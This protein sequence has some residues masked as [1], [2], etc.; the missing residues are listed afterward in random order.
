MGVEI[1]VRHIGYAGPS[2]SGGVTSWHGRSGAV[3]IKDIDA[4]VGVYSGGTG[5]GTVRKLNFIGAGNTFFHNSTTNTVDISITGAGGTFKHY[6]AGIATSRNVLGINTSNLDVV[7]MDTSA[8]VYISNGMLYYDNAL[9][10]NHYISTAHNGLM[11][12][13]VTIHNILTVD[14]NYVVV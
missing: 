6:N 3:G 7:G 2:G 4:V 11:A 5:I 12:G 1:Q 14:G 8:G 10:G 13:P 9:Y